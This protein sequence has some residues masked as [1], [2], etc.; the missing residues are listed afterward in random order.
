MRDLALKLY[1]A[2]GRLSVE[3]PKSEPAV[4]KVEHVSGLESHIQTLSELPEPI[5]DPFMTLENPAK[6]ESL[7]TRVELELEISVW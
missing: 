3:E 7:M 5:E 2:R 1:S 6:V 4:T